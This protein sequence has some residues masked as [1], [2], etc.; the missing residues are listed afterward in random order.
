VD[1]AW[2]VGAESGL[3]FEWSVLGFFFG[4]RLILGL[5][6]VWI[7]LESSGFVLERIGRFGGGVIRCR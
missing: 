6:H 5:V 1:E 2:G 7:R 4:G 3:F